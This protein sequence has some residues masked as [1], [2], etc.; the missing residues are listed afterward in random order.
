MARYKHDCKKC[1][2]LGEFE[3]YDLYICKHR[4]YTRVIAQYGDSD[5]FIA[6][7]KN[8]I[9]GIKVLDIAVFKNV[10]NE[11]DIGPIRGLLKLAIQ[12]YVTC[13]R[14]ENSSPIALKVILNKSFRKPFIV[15]GT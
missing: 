7:A 12:T 9:S 3:E 10:F 6:K 11:S 8:D 2:F 4:D 1:T 15:D 5:Y 14:V 13:G